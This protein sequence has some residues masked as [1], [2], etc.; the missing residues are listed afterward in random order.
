MTAT[1]AA[2]DLAEARRLEAEGRRA[3]ALEKVLRV[4]TRDPLYREAARLAVGLACATDALSVRFEQFVGPFIAAGPTSDDELPLFYDLGELYLRHEMPENA[5][6]VFGKIIDRAPDYRDVVD[7][8][9]HVADG[10]ARLDESLAGL[11]AEDERF[12]RLAPRAGNVPVAATA[13]DDVLHPTR[14]LDPGAAGAAASFAPGTTV[15]DRYRIEGE[16]GRG[17]MAVVYRAQDLELSEQVALKVFR[18]TA[19]DEG[20]IARF[21]QELKLSRRLSHV[22]IT[23]FYDLG[24]H[25]GHRYISMEL[26]VGHSLEELAGAPWMLRRGLDTLI[27][28]CEGLEAAH[29][30]GVIHR[31]IKPANLFLTREGIAKIMDFGIARERKATGLTQVGMIV[32]TPEYLSPE[33]IGGEPATEASDLY[34]L[35]VVAYEMFTGRKPFVHDQLLPLLQMHVTTAPA[36]PSQYRPGLDPGLEAVILKLLSKRPSERYASARALA[37]A[38]R[39]LRDPPPA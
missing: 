26:L 9:S 20:G 2:A 35:G 22:N 17:G 36:P 31:D 27:Q 33:Q 32:G 8:L 18:P 28:V 24:V 16:I 34:A 39:A 25:A 6:E 1:G 3:A 5:E 4:G 14:P 19:Y 10:G 15:A 30:Q 23:R 7:R 37:D 38:L 12:R 21:R 29:A 11:F 13:M